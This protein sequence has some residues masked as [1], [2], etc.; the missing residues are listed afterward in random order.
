MPESVFSQAIH[1][2]SLASSVLI[3]GI[4]LNQHKVFIR[5]KDR[6]DVLWHKHQE[7]KGEPFIPLDNGHS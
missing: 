5:M 3:L 2:G 1:A 4:L 6:L 7:E